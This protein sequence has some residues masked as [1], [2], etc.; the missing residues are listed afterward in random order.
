[1]TGTWTLVPADTGWFV[2]YWYSTDR[3]YEAGPLGH[4]WTPPGP[5]SPGAARAVKTFAPVCAQ[6]LPGG[7]HIIANY[8]AAVDNLTQA[9]VPTSTDPMFGTPPSLGS[10]VFVVQTR[11]DPNQPNNPTT[12][13][14]VIDVHETIPNPWGDEWADPFNQPSFVQR[15]QDRLEPPRR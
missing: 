14:H 10:D 5:G 7:R 9:N 3:D 15:S 6:R 1:L 2:P 13:V 11:Y 8:A 12:Q 4:L